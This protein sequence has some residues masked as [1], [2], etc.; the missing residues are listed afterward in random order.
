MTTLSS[1]VGEPPMPARQEAA[2][3][4]LLAVNSATDLFSR[5]APAQIRL[6][7]LLQDPPAMTS[8]LGGRRHA[9]AGVGAL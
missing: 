3:V 2:A 1:V 7:P 6:F 4:R 5:E 9:S 8:M